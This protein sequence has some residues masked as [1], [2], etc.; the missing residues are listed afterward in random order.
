MFYVSILL[1][2]LRIAGAFANLTK[3][4]G[5]PV[6]RVREILPHLQSIEWTVVAIEAAF[7]AAGT[8]HNRKATDFF[9]PVRFAVSGQG[10][11]AHLIGVLHAL[12]RDLTL[13]RLQSFIA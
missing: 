7:N 13:G 8:A 9:A 5:D 3:K 2:Q 12:G 1:V 10:G 6:A 4:G 11:G